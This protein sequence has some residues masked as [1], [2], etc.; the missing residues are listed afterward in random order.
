MKPPPTGSDSDPKAG[1]E[2]APEGRRTSEAGPLARLLQAAAARRLALGALMVV[3]GVVATLSVLRMPVQLLPEIRYPQIRIIS[4]LPGQTARVV[5]ESVNEPIEAALAAVPGIVRLESRSGDGRSYLD[6]FFPP[7]SDLDRALNDVTQAVQR[8]RSQIPASFPEPRVFAVSTLQEPALEIAVGS[9]SLDVPEIRQRLRGPLLPRLRAIPGVEAVYMGREEIP[10]VAVDVDPGRQVAAGVLLADL[11]AVLLEAARPPLSSPLRAPGFEGVGVLGVDGWSPE[12]L[13]A[14]PVPARQGAVRLPIGSLATVSRG[15]SE[16]RLFTRLDGAPSVLVSVHRAPT[17][18]ALRLAREVREVLDELEGS[19]LFADLDATILFDDAVV[20]RSAVRSTVTA[21]LG[22]S[23][24]AVLLLLVGLRQRRY[25]PLV[26]VVVGGSLAA[27]L[28]A[29][30]AAGQTMNLLTLAGLLLSVGLGL[31][32][33]II[34]F[35]RLDRADPAQESP[36]LRAMEEVAGPLLGALLTTLAAVLPFLLV[37]GMVALLFRPLIWT[38]VAA[39]IFSF[40]FAVLILPAF[41]RRT[42]VA[43]SQAPPGAILRHRFLAPF[44][45]TLGAVGAS[46]GLAIVLVWGMRSL[47]FEVLPVVDDGFVD[48][49]I[50]HPSGIP[51]SG[52]DAIARS[53]EE[54]LRGVKGTE[55]LSTTVG[56]YFREGLPAFRPASTDF[57]VRVDIG[58]TG[59]TSQEWAGEARRVVADLGFPGLQVTVT[60]PR[61]RGVQTRLADDDLIVVLSRDDGD[62]LE[63]A[64]LEAPVMERLREVPGLTGIRRLRGG[65]SPRWQGIPRAERL[66]A[67]G[68]GPAELERAMA[69]ALEGR[70]IAQRM[71]GGEPLALRVRYDR[72]EAGG[73]DAL[74]GVP[75]LAGG[76]GAIRLSDVVEFQ[77]VEE[78]THIERREGNRVVR[79]AGQLDPAGPGAGAVARSV[80]ESLRGAELPDGTRWWLEGEIDALQETSRTFG[81]SLGLALVLVLAVLS[82]QYGSIAF[83]LAGVLTIP[84]SA[85]GAVALLALLGRPLDGM[86]LAGLLIAVGIVANNVILV[87][88]E[89]ARSGALSARGLPAREALARAADSRLRPITLTVLST[90]LGMS[91]LLLGG[92]EVFGLLQPLA[93]A[94]IGSLLLS[95]PVAC[96][97]LPGVAGGLAGIGGGR[98]GL[99]GQGSATPPEPPA[100]LPDAGAESA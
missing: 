80:R 36:H 18:H 29:L 63:L 37:E 62:L 53:V 78:P 73:P 56:G 86:V 87:L 57:M 12:W 14:Q 46:V 32:Y 75:I 35:D 82:I 60:P 42:R 5:E 95:I 55:A 11:E 92:V 88:S 22:G 83:A 96:L 93:I 69:Y 85:A 1:S 15:S 72:R 43:P 84:L 24:L 23:L 26:A 90:S 76:A 3:I 6:L 39:G 31:D 59:V 25:A 48:V 64:E 66:V 79:V 30:A 100:P 89:A 7:G 33:A 52:M 41:A 97:I 17:G 94:L 67:V 58:G 4:D 74:S 34:Y 51:L 44:R 61:I 19:G 27:A 54:A 45:T 8:A 91:P 65:A 20:T 2:P 50:V 9:A 77:L 81:L 49:R 16:E 70:V 40:L 28:V 98:P 21:I 10:E 47:P 99:S 13:A 38:V 71:D 68:L